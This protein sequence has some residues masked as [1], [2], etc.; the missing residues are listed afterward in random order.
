MSAL[1]EPP[2]KRLKVSDL[3]K[4]EILSA[5]VYYHVDKIGTSLEV[6]D[7]GPG[8]GSTSSNRLNY[9][10]SVAERE[11]FTASQF[12]E[13][14]KCS[15]TD[16][17]NALQGAGDTI[18]TVSFKKKNGDIRELRGCRIPGIPDTCFGRSA[19]YDLDVTSYAYNV[20]EGG[21]IVHRKGETFSSGI[22]EEQKRPHRKR[23]V[24][25]RTV[26]QLILKNVKYVL[27]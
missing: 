9:G 10:A 26:F 21:E 18:F 4:G 20:K 6:H 19:V 12:N 22:T 23:E 14:R 7:L 2:S 3:K 11:A 17:V 8:Q 24:D 25:H 13:V 16:I 1:I 27:K 15:R 5:T